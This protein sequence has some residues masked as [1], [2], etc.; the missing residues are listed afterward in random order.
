[1]NGA[2]R[3]AAESGTG[4]RFSKA[5]A[6]ASFPVTTGLAV[7]LG[8]SGC[9][10][11]A[12]IERGPYTALGEVAAKATSNMLADKGKVVLLVS[13]ADNNSATAVGL[14]VKTFKDVLRQ[15]G[16]AQVAATE[17]IK[18]TVAIALSGAEPL[19]PARFVELVSKHASADALVSFAGVPRLTLEQIGQLPQAR[20]KV[21]A[22]V[23]YN[24]PT[25]AMFARGVL[26]LAILARPAAD[27]SV[28]T[29]TTTQEW[30]DA[31]YQLLTPATAGLMPF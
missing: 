19:T 20:P 29:P 27:T 17:T 2:E 11:G 24:P 3:Q 6:A 4:K 8:L 22:V 13:E 31:N 18:P 5:N 1:M 12:K 25:K 23:T 16:G 26:H 15:T 28:R 14:A 9:G 10:R 21:V 7:L 30:F